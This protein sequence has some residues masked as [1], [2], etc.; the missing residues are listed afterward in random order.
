MHSKITS[1]I[2]LE[3]PVKSVGMKLFLM[4]F[5]SILFFVLTVGMISYSV[6]KS[7]IKNKVSE[8]SLQTVT[9]AGQKLDFLYQTFDDVSLQI[10]LNK[11][12]QELLD[13]VPKLD[14][15]S[16]EA[17]DITRQLTE[18]LN[19]V[20]FSNKSIKTLHLYRPDGKLIVITGSGG[21]P[22]AEN[23][24]TTDW[25]KQ[26]IENG[27]K[28]TWLDSQAKGY[29]NSSTNTFAISRL[30]RNTLTNTATAVLLLELKHRYFDERAKRNVL[31]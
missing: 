12:L 26:T 23:S 9:Q 15:S 7:V 19:V 27:G 21:S 1:N 13:K 3:N 14:P 18:K 4:F 29:S 22:A 30:M 31:R 24:A 10:M 2:K 8:S 6:S 28:V 25:F 5:I 17:L 11:E 16:Y 20:T